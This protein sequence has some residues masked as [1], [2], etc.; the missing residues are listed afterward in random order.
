ME[1]VDGAGPFSENMNHCNPL[2]FNSLRRY[3]VADRRSDR[4]LSR[5]GRER[6]ACGR[7]DGQKGDPGGIPDSRPTR[8]EEAVKHKIQGGQEKVPSPATAVARGKGLTFSR[9]VVQAGP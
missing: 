5:L 6:A 2:F 7:R 9:V 1:D 3:S 8:P 4:G